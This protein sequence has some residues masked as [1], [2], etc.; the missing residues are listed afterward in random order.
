MLY[1]MLLKPALHTR[2]WGG[3]RLETELGKTLPTAEPYGESWELHDSAVIANGAHAGRTV[4]EALTGL[5]TALVGPDFDLTE[6]FPLLIKFLDANDWL[7][8]QV[9]PDDAQARVLE[10]QPR[11]KTEAWV[12]LD[13]APGARLVI[14]VKPG[15]DR[16]AMARAIE[17]N[18]L[19][20]LVVYAEVAAGD[21]LY[22]AA[23]TV[24]AL[25]P[26]TLIYEVQQSSDL[27]YR[28]Y[29]WGRVG[30][31][32]KPRPLHIDKGVQVS[33]VDMTPPISRAAASDNEPII[34]G[35]FFTTYLHHLDDST[36]TLDTGLRTFH[37]LTC[38][39][40]ALTVVSADG[41]SLSLKRGDTVLIPAALGAYTLTGRG[42][43][44]RSLPAGN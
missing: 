10:D 12:V 35:A 37:A 19:E 5:G 43:V 24:H 18:A 34:R 33:N 23:G 11:G 20:D 2:V 4:G 44:L 8:V 16:A 9:H 36:L 15:T 1:P 41:E 42:D 17:L 38:T 40:G 31:D 22:M 26:G 28:L 21:V 27:T 13:A 7:S 6:G 39:G 14:G 30:L 32:G 3:R 29:D 25:G